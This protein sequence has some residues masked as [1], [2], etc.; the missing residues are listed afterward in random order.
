MIQPPSPTGSFTFSAIGS[1]LPGVA[2]TGTPLASFLLGQVQTFLDRSAATQIQERAHFQEYFVQDDWKVS[3]R[4]TVNPGLRYTLNFPSTEI[5]GQTAVF[6]L[7]TQQLE[8]PGT[9]PV[10][11]LKK[12]NFGPRLG[13]VYRVTDKTIA[14]R[15]LRPDLDRDGGHHDAV[16]DADV[17]VS[18]DGHAANARQHHPGVRAAER[19]DRR[20]GRA[21]TPTAG[22]GQGV[23]A[24]DG[25]LGSGY[26]QQWNVSVQ[27]ELT[28]NTIVEVAY[29]GSKITH[30]GIPD[31]NL[32]QLTRR[33]AGAR[34]R[35]ARSACR[36][37]TS[38]S[39]RGRR[40]SATRRFRARSS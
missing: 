6:N 28:T 24:V 10:R 26:A 27:R 33:S 17:S 13:A 4:L 39:F 15:R 14:E 29:V 34:L 19:T 32:N 11:P 21:T 16:H 40:R 35:A 7:Q 25:N 31:S 1:D 3:D 8:Y 36:I 18:A 2:N 5:N 12:N 9:N 30:V 22:L 20:A 23:F 37:R 38:A